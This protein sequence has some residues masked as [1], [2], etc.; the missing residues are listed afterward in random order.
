MAKTIA[1]PQA[2]LQPRDWRCGWMAG[3]GGRWCRGWR[4]TD[5]VAF[6]TLLQA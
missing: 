2:M 1:K 4:V 6:A 5:G 3:A